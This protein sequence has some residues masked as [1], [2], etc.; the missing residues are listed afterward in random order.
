DVYKRQ[1]LYRPGPMAHIPRFIRSKF[2]REPIEYLHPAL[3]PILKE[4]YGVIC[5][6]E[7]VL[8][9]AQAIAGFSL[10]QADVLRKAMSAK[11]REVMDEMRARFIEGAKANGFSEKIA[12]KIFE[13]IEPFAGYAFNKAHAVCYAFV[14]YRTAYMKANYPVEYYAALLSANMDDKDKLAAYMADCKRLG[15]KVLPPDV[16]SS[17]AR[18]EVAPESS[19]ALG[20]LEEKTAC[21][22]SAQTS[23]SQG[24]IH[25][26][27]ASIKGCGRAA[28]EAMV[29]ERN[30]GG[31]FK[32]LF[33]FCARCQESAGMNRAMVEALIK[34][35]AFASIEPNRAR[36]LAMLPDA[37]AAASAK[38]RD[39]K[40]GQAGLFGGAEESVSYRPNLARYDHVAEFSLDEILAMEK[41]HVGIYLSGHPLDSVRSRLERECTANAQTFHDL[42]D[43]KECTVGGIITEVRYRR[44]RRNESMASIRLEDL[45]G[46]IPVTFF[47]AAFK[48][49]SQYIAKDRIVIIKG[50]ASHRERI[51]ADDEDA[52]VE[53]EILGESIKPI[54]NGPIENGNGARPVHIK[55]EGDTRANLDILK[56]L[57]ESY[58]GESPLYFHL[59]QSGK[60]RRIAT[61]YRV[62]ACPRFVEEVE[63]VLG[64]DVVRIA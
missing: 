29:A 35:G 36:L 16:N 2:G 64:R 52:V 54:K 50:K 3:E 8:R 22:S 12:A 43:E 17:T 40:S 53:V 49:C 21:D 33:D 44:T 7:Q 26:G 42:E 11:K 31:P 25:F 48:V 14:A 56:S 32:D 5:Y 41:E 58:P 6:Q 28:I 18:F 59:C 39:Q 13:Q 10:G 23:N 62:D 34:V 27:L 47:P 9:I 1:A 20:E 38:L 61:P 30:R 15:I 60:R 19:P 24:Q 37:M 46:S 4:T 57:I 63:R 45:H 55:I 51:A